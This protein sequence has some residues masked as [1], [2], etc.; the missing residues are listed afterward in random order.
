MSTKSVRFIRTATH[1][2]AEAVAALLAD[3]YGTLLAGWYEPS[4]LARALPIIT[5]ANPKLLAS[6]TYD[7]MDAGDGRLLGCGGWTAE[8]PGTGRRLAGEAHI[9]HVATDPASL[10]QGIGTA[11][12][13]HCLAQ[14]EA[15]SIRRLTCFSTLTAET[16]YRSCGF[17]TVGPTTIPL[18]PDLAFPALLMRRSLP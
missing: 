7:V 8:E 6:G 17:T 11:L 12:L 16:F 2:D 13:A 4:L 5:K 9:R 14:G 15:Q 3:C 18:A 10:R 1:A